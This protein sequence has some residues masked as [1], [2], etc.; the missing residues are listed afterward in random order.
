MQQALPAALSLSQ[1][2]GVANGARSNGSRSDGGSVSNDGT[3]PRRPRAGSAAPSNRF[4]VVNVDADHESE[5]PIRSAS[6]TAMSTMSKRY[7]SAEEE[8]RRI[9][10]AMNKVAVQDGS[11]VQVSASL[12][13]LG[14]IPDYSEAPSGSSSNPCDQQP[15][16]WLSAEEEKARLGQQNQAYEAARQRA[17]RMQGIAEAGFAPS[18]LP[19]IQARRLISPCQ[20]SP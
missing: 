19:V 9:Q 11:S 14:N 15:K 1:V 13:N 16:K 5:A 20:R 7:P 4:T 2:N 6:A 8:K 17:A 12:N 18:S 3:G 10:E